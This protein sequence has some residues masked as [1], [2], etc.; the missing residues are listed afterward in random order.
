MESLNPLHT[1]ERIEEMKLPDA[2]LI[3]PRPWNQVEREDLVLRVWVR[4]EGEGARARAGSGE[5]E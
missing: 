2:D 5:G 3:I 1:R 4:G